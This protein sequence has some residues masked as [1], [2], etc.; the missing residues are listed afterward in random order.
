MISLEEALGIPTTTQTQITPKQ[1]QI[2]PHPTSP[3]RVD[4][5]IELMDEIKYLKE[6]RQLIKDGV[7]EADKKLTASMYTTQIILSAYRIAL[8]AQ[9]EA[10]KIE[11][12][13]NNI[14][15]VNHVVK[16][17]KPTRAAANSDD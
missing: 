5:L 13:Q 4:L 7:I 8:D 10:A 15:Q 2:T 12:T 1:T 11:V 17:V 6:T 16:F 14:T 3:S 9:K